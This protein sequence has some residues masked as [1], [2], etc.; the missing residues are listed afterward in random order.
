M[1][2]YT[3]DPNGILGY[4]VQLSD[5]RKHALVELVAQNP[6]AFKAIMADKTPDVKVFQKGK[7]KQA[8]IEAEFRKYET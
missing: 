2:G 4:T 5:D 7:D 6:A 8:D 1:K 3:P